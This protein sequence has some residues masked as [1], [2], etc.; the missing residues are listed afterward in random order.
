[1]SP[2]LQADSLP[3]EPQG[4]PSQT[5]TVHLFNTKN[6]TFIF[7][8]FKLDETSHPWAFFLGTY[9]KGGD[10][11]HFQSYHDISAHNKEDV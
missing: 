2:T 4:K 7:Y 3:A 8:L 9:I 10:P 11:G 5:L 6:V 1:M